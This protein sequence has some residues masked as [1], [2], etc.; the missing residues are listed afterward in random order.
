VAGA[1]ADDVELPLERQIVGNRG[2]AADEELL[3]DRL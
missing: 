2:M 1:P 3:D